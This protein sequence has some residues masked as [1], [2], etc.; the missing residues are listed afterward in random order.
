MGGLISLYAL[1]THHDVFGA[2]GCLSTHW[3]I[4]GSYL[5]QAISDLL[6]RPG[7]HRI[8]YDYGTATLDAEYEPFQLEM[9][10]CMEMAGYRRDIDWV[11]RKFLEADHSE[12]AWR[13]RVDIPLAFLLQ[14]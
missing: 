14:G 4:G 5:V 8:Y 11:T 13:T 7:V 10:H 6:P 2:A 12:A 9:D 3:P 1:C